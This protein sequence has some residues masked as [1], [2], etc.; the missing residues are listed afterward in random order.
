MKKIL[1]ILAFAGLSLSAAN[2][3]KK[4]PH[5]HRLATEV[6]ARRVEIVLPQVKGYNCYKGDFHVHTIYSDGCINPAGRIAEA[7]YDGLD[8]VA[9]TDHYEG[10]K[11]LKKAAIVAAPVNPDGKPIKYPSANKVGKVCADFNAIH[12]EAV[13]QL[14]KSK[15]P[16]LLIKGCEMARNSQTHGHFN[17]LFVDDIN[18]LYNR[19]VAEAF[20][21]VKKQGGIIIHNHPAWRRK[22]SDKTEF[23]KKVY[24][25]G[26]IDGV[27]VVNG[28]TFYPHI[29]RRCIDEKL[30]MFGN[31]DI[32]GFTNQTYDPSGSHRTMTLVLAKE[33]T[34]KSVKD[35]ILKNRTIVYAVGTL[36][37]EEMWL[38]EF[39]NA[40]VTCRLLNENKTKGTR[41]YTLTNMS[42]ITYHLRKGKSQLVLEPFRT[43]TISTSKDK[44]SGKFLNPKYEVTNMW[45][46]DYKHPVIEIETD[47]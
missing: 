17:C 29:V 43:I 42:S 10:Q 8:I 26:L 14:E 32:H 2:A 35:A 5:S 25:E 31:T 37:G 15:Y 13:D 39:F 7:W 33:L 38:K 30:T 36:I 12:Q 24:D 40:A 20:R 16:M 22:T 11:G 41:T 44:K 18:V 27:E 45:H 23:H 28:G 34:E 9:I 46:I 47:K 3:Q 6:R 19:D 4:I 1:L 21:N